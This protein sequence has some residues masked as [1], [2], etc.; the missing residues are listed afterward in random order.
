MV[1]LAATKRV[2]RLHSASDAQH[3]MWSYKGPEPVLTHRTRL[4]A[5]HRTLQH[6]VHAE[7]RKATDVTISPD[8]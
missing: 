8:A 1:D 2:R 6:P 4:T 7:L 5:R 3:P